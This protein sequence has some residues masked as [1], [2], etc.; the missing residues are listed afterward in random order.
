[1]GKKRLSVITKK[2]V[3][4]IVIADFVLCSLVYATSYMAFNRQ[5]TQQ[6]DTEI[7]DIAEAA[8]S[9]LNPEDFEKYKK[10]PVPD[11]KW[12]AVI[13]DLQRIVDNFNLN[14]IYVSA[15]DAPDY[16]HIFYFYDPV[17]KV[18]KWTSYPLGYEEDYF[19]PSYHATTVRVYEEVFLGQPLLHLNRLGAQAQIVRP[20]VVGETA[21]V[22]E[23]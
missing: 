6:Y 3:L 7:Q 18:T 20:P 11:E 15:V 10:E 23:I 9:F 5:F 21:Q 17:G 8:R 2:I 13:D 1:M 14:V 4:Y 12:Y 19:E 22:G 16:T